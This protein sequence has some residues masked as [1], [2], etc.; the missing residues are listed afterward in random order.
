MLNGFQLSKDP[1]GGIDSVNDDSTRP[2]EEDVSSFDLV[3]EKE[4]RRA[5]V[6]DLVQTIKETADKLAAEGSTRGDLK[7]LSRTLRELRYAFKVFSPYRRRRKVTVFGSARTQPDE[8]AYV[9]AM[10]FGRAMAQ[11]GWLVI[12][13]AAS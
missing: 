4:D 8:P 10:D 7:I 6:A 13:G 12:T 9:Q 5:H 3:S 11:A 2:T 1:R